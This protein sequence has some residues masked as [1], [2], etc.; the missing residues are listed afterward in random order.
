MRLYLIRLFYIICS[1]GSYFS[2][3]HPPFEDVEEFQSFCRLI[4]L[5]RRWKLMG[6]EYFRITKQLQQKFC[7][8]IKWISELLY[9]NW[10]M[11]L[12]SWLIKYESRTA[13][14]KKQL[15]AASSARLATILSKSW[16]DMICYGWGNWLTIRASFL[17]FSLSCSSAS[18]PFAIS[19]R[20]NIPPRQSPSSAT[21]PINLASIW[22]S[23][24][25]RMEINFKMEEMMEVRDFVGSSC[26][27]YL[28]QREI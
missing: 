13:G 22:G 8:Q 11:Q 6:R 19:V 26:E 17:T 23:L 20:Y 5:M 3:C 28:M 15:S 16:M 21:V 25:R 14:I 12:R 9:N 1:I 2:R 4:Y 7:Q 10:L 18:Q 24:N 27:S